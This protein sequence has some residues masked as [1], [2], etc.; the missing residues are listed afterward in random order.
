MKILVGFDGSANATEA[1]AWAVDEATVRGCAVEVLSVL[2]VPALAY[3]AP[4]YVPPTMDRFRSEMLPLVEHALERAGRSRPGIP[5]ELNV[6]EG[7]AAA[8]LA[9]RAKAPDVALVVVGARGHG[10][11]TELMLGSASHALS[12]T[13]PKPLVIV[14]HDWSAKRPAA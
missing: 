1:L 2:A 4:G 11:I 7:P 9:E 6:G 8:I 5:V 13:C 3:G 10:V 12:H 14:P